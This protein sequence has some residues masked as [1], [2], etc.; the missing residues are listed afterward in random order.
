MTYAEQLAALEA[1]LQGKVARRDW[2]GVADA[3]CDLRELEAVEV[4]IERERRDRVNRLVRSL[5]TSPD[6]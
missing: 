4:A 5:A 6:A 2:H 3:A 1:D